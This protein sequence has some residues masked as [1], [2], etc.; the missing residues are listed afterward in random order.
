[1]LSCSVL[2]RRGPLVFALLVG[3]S[4]ADTGGSD[5]AA[6]GNPGTLAGGSANGGHAGGVGPATG[7]TQTVISGASGASG[8]SNTSGGV[9]AGGAAGFSAGGAAAGSA[10]GG[11]AGTSSAGAAGAETVGSIKL[12]AIGTNG[13]VGLDWDR[14]PGATSYRVYWSTSAGVM[15]GTAQVLESMEPALVHRALT[16]GTAY[17]YVVTAVTA[18][19]ESARSNAAT[20]TPAGEWVLEQLGSGD[21]Q[22]PTSD[23]RVAR[24]PLAARIHLLLLP[25]GYQ[26]ADLPG[27]HDHAA[28]SLATPTNDV[29]RWLREVFAIE[30]YSLFREAFVVWYLPRA[31]ATRVNAAPPSTAFGI[32][33]SGAGVGSVSAAAAPLW[34]A[35]DDQGTDAFPFVPGTSV[36]NHVAAFLILDGSRSPARAGFSGLSTSLTNPARSGQRIRSAFAQGHAHELTHAFAGLADE[37]LENDQTVTSSSETSNVVASNVCSALPWAH[38]LAGGGI[39]STEQLVGAF[40]RAQR[41][42]HSELLCLMNGTHD[43]GEYWCGSAATSLTLRPNDRMCNWCRELASY[44]VF[45]KTGILSGSS[46][47]QSWKTSYRA[48]FYTRFGFKLPATVPQRFRCGTAPEMPL[49]EDCTR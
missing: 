35:L 29:D 14:V 3:C 27:F 32:T 24:V 34:S 23:Q 49:F 1:M 41:G 45:E 2:R 30:P 28:H 17:H 39:N 36:L 48:G 19:G 42:Y 33:L 11:A 8:A 44:R 16:N 26:Q 4:E 7:G 22:D 13:T 43:N 46:S 18:A 15:P 40:G 38:L 20:A 31:S 25:E 6:S 12:S 5:G 9:E 37:Y 21:F 10:A 47:F